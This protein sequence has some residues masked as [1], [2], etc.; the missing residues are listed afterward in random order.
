MS[1]YLNLEVANIDSPSMSS[2]TTELYQFFKNQE[3]LC[4]ALIDI[5]KP[6]LLLKYGGKGTPHF[7]NFYVSQNFDK[8][9]WVSPKKSNAEVD[10]RDVVKLLKGRQTDKFRKYKTEVF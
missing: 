5:K 2:E 8:L 9:F 10:F 7:R 3:N 1:N 6:T 4:Q